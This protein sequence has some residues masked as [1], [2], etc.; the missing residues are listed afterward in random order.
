MQPLLWLL[1]AVWIK[2]IQHLKKKIIIKHM[3]LLT[4]G[5]QQPVF[6]YTSFS[7]MDTNFK[8]SIDRPTRHTSSRSLLFFINWHIDAMKYRDPSIVMKSHIATRCV[9]MGSSA[10]HPIARAIRQRLAVGLMV[11]TTK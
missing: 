9:F 10:A 1:T 6:A 7:H 3:L 8:K 2:Q 4:A 11:P 5:A